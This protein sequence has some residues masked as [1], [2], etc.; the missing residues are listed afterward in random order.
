[1]HPYDEA[2][3]TCGKIKRRVVKSA[4]WKSVKVIYNLRNEWSTKNEDDK[5]M[6]FLR[7]K[8]SFKEHYTGIAV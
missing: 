6:Y 2:V 4:Q 5:N 8:T 7:Q 1:M 3:H